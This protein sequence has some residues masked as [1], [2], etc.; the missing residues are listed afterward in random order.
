MAMLVSGSVDT[1]AQML[2]TPQNLST[3]VTESFFS[4]LLSSH[5]LHKDLSIN[6]LL[7]PA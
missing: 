7:I 6:N 4:E 1:N 3:I 2:R 5:I